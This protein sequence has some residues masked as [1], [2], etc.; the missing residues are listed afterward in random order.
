MSAPEVMVVSCCGRTAREAAEEVATHLATMPGFADLPAV[1]TRPTRFFVVG[2]A[3]LSRP[4]PR[5]VDGIEQLAALLHPEMFRPEAA[6]DALHLCLGAG[7][8]IPDP[9]E[10]ATRFVPLCL[11][12]DADARY[13]EADREAAAAASPWQSLDSA[14]GP[15]PK[16]AHAAVAGLG[17]SQLLIV[18]G[19]ETPD[20]GGVATISSDVWSASLSHSLSYSCAA[21]RREICTGTFGEDVPSKRSNHAAA[22]WGDILLVFG[23]WNENG[24]RPL[25]RLE[26]LH[27][28]TLCWTHGSATGTAPPPRGNPSLVV[29][30][31]TSR[32]VLFG[33]WDGARRFDDLHVLDLQRWHWERVECAGVGPGARTDHAACAWKGEGMLLHGG[34]SQ[35]GPLGDLWLLRWGEAACHWRWEE[36]LPHGGSVPR[37]RGSHVMVAVGDALLILGGQAQGALLGDAHVLLLRSRR[38]LPAPSLPRAVCRHGAAALDCGVAVW[39]GWDGTRCV[40]DLLLLPSADVWAAC[41]LRRREV[42]GP[43]EGR[44]VRAIVLAAESGQPEPER[45]PVRPEAWEEAAPLS[46]EDVEAAAAEGKERELRALQGLQRVAPARRE[47][48]TW[49]TLH[50]LANAAGL[51]QYLD[52]ASGYTVFTATYL[53]RRPCCGHTCRHCPHG[54]VNVPK[55]L[56]E[57][58]VDDW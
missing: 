1:K 22:V 39:G 8:E 57:A 54:H 35:A 2:H 58:V 12:W 23:G 15:V 37:P 11:A 49:A 42:L 51:D 36:I 33:G 24:N 43:E 19:E 5:V 31:A 3:L 53:K 14:A 13:L 56:Q 18:A 41:G 26:L 20:G 34:S 38:W 28:R 27:L 4:G 50:R 44:R 30:E 47:Q 46:L 40:S 7:E 16:A 25:A 9:S 29:D 32:A 21:W 6:R 17:P 52:P 55:G 45:S 48:A 10:L